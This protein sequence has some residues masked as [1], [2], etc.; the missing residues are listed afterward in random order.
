MHVAS[1]FAQLSSIGATRCK[2]YL[3]MPR[4]LLTVY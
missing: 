1:C 3:G 2:S 4:K